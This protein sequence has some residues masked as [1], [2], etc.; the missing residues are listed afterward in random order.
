MRSLSLFAGLLLSLTATNVSAIT[1]PDNTAEIAR[2]LKT[3]LAEA[4]TMRDSIYILENLSDLYDAGARVKILDNVY[5]LYSRVDDYKKMGDILRKKANISLR[6]D[7]ILV[8]VLEKAM[9]FPDSPEKNETVAFIRMMRT[10]YKLRH[11][12]PVDKQ[13]RLNEMLGKL[14]SNP[15]ENLYDHIVLLHA[16]CMY[17]GDSSRGE[18]LSKYMDKLGHLID[19]LPAEAYS[20]RNMYNIQAAIAYSEN[21]EA[22]KAIEVDKN[23]LV[24]IDSL[25]QKYHREGRKYRDLDG[26]RYVV[27]TRLLSN[28]EN[29]S[30]EEVEDYYEKAQNL[31]RVNGRAAVTYRNSPLID[32]YYSMFKKDYPRAL[33]LLKT[34]ID[35]S[36]LKPKRRI[37]LK[38]MMDASKEVCDQQALL[39]ASTGYSELMEEFI[40]EK[41]K[42]RY[43]ELQIIYDVYNMKNDYARLQVE[44]QESE[45][46]LQRNIIIITCI[47]CVILLALLVI[48]I[49]LNRKTKHLA[50]TLAESNAALTIES[51]NLRK[52]RA[53]SMRIRD[54][55]IKANSFKT[56]FIKNMSREVQIPLQ[57]ITEYTG[58]IV[59]C[60]DLSHK[61]YLEKFSHLV[62]LNSELLNTMVNDM[63]SLADFD[64][65]SSSIKINK[66]I[67][68]LY[69]ICNMVVGTVNRRIGD[70]VEIVFDAESQANINIFTDTQRVQQ[71]LINLLTNAVKFTQQGYIKLLVKTADDNSKIQFIVEDTGIGIPPEKKDLIFERFYKISKDSQG[72]GLG[73]TISRMFAKLLNG[74]LELDTTYTS[75]ARFIL[76][77]PIE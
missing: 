30:P 23:M 53:E 32:I 74:S 21:G 56:D 7:S 2:N 20:L 14:T 54:I 8:N 42:E 77:I 45:N 16:I 29:L 52:S 69:D 49:R 37:L 26:N 34:V 41:F 28:F 40:D 5:E 70:G 58:L 67:A 66:K 55:A 18:L 11:G 68:N 22:D 17:I 27:Y 57:A 9:E 73:L 33:S 13:S 61:K 24:I 3:Q 4:S 44:K 71:I 76:T 63:L 36:R 59:D 62:E 19:S 35:D 1:T 38:Y 75:G 43:N 50:K 46:A 47:S 31:I 25:E 39:K 51:E 6:N 15:P 65:S 64:S 12:S 60:S 72:A 48:L 10:N